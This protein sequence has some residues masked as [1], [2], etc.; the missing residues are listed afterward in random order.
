MLNFFQKGKAGHMKFKFYSWLLAVLTIVAFTS[1]ASAETCD[2]RVSACTASNSVTVGSTT[3][4]KTYGQ[5]AFSD[6]CVFTCSACSSGYTK[7]AHTYT[8]SSGCTIDYHTCK[9]SSGG[10]SD[11]CAT[12]TV[13]S[14]ASGQTVITSNANCAS[15]DSTYICATAGECVRDCLSCNSGYELTGVM[16]LDSN[17]C[18]L[19]YNGCLSNPTQAE[20]TTA[21]DCYGGLNPLW[22]SVSG[23]DGVQ[24][25]VSYTCP[26]GTCVSE[27]LY[28]CAPGYAGFVFAMPTTGALRGTCSVC[29]SGYYSTGGASECTACP[30]GSFTNATTGAIRCTS[31]VTATGN[32]AAT[33][34]APAITSES[35][36]L[37]TGTQMSSDE[38][39]TKKLL[40]N[41]YYESD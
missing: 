22:I 29:E 15:Q 7:V 31:C 9:E 32:E 39:G 30:D 3:G 5:M 8:D 28:R 16:A 6:R 26:S 2:Y 23:H 41:C 10:V 1:N 27:T 35:C 13:T 36:F 38:I 40:E 37:P 34:V 25:K 17:G 33:S 20:C 21:S 19:N 14:L 4:C 24:S 18:S 12:T 11:L